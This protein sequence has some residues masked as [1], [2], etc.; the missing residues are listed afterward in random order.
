MIARA[1]SAARTAESIL[2][3]TLGLW[4]RLPYDQIRLDAIAAQAGVTVPT[5]VR[6]FGSK[7]GA[8]CALVDRELDA[9]ERT[10]R[11][12]AD[13]STGEIVDHLVVFYEEFGLA[14]LKLYS[15]APFV[16]GL[17]LRAARAREQH[18]G[19]LRT[20][21]GGRVSGDQRAHARRLAQVIAALDATTW[22]ILRHE[23]DLS[24]GEVALAFTELLE[25]L[26]RGDGGAAPA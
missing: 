17:A 11:P 26:V 23:N 5:V 19:W 24:Q 1:D 8:L 2:D 18:V 25:P 6:R 14:I 15:E 4:A 16:E 12:L 20:V 7:A 22:R 13:A 10:R 9:L 21:F 3:A